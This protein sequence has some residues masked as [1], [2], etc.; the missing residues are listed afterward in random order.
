MHQRRDS[1]QNHLPTYVGLVQASL[2]QRWWTSRDLSGELGLNIQTVS[3]CIRTIA[4]SR[5]VFTRKTK[6]RGKPKAYRIFPEA[7]QVRKA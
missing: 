7:V 2:L 4:R 6:L 5:Y 1:S 3:F